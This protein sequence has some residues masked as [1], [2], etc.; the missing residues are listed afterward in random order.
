[1]INASAADTKLRTE[2]HSVHEQ[3]TQRHAEKLVTA[4]AK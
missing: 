1:M 4:D 3:L 2:T